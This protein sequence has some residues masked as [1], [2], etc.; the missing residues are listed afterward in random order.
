MKRSLTKAEI[1]RRKSDIK[2]VFGTSDVYRTQ[3]LHLRIITN[4]L[5]WSRVLFTTPRIMKGAVVRNRSRRRVR[6]AYRHVKSRIDGHYDMAFVIYPGD[7]GFSDRMR[8]ME[9]LLNQADCV[10]PVEG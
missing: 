1:L 6:E 2:R 5:G 10:R 7:F 8:Q 3:G 9:T 4:D